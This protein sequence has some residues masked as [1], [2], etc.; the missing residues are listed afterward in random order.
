MAPGS[1][2]LELWCLGAEL[3]QE[4]RESLPC[5]EHRAVT[6]LCAMKHP[7]GQAFI[8]ESLVG[9]CALGI[10]VCIH[11]FSR[12]CLEWVSFCFM[13]KRCE[14]ECVCV[15]APKLSLN[16]CNTAIKPLW[17]FPFYVKGIMKCLPIFT[18][19]GDRCQTWAQA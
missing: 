9:T 3:V 12:S 1:S 6:S 2:E 13:L 17:A 15:S 19:S 10:L 11:C 7:R 16:Q 14:L 5:L 4:G 18:H 8:A